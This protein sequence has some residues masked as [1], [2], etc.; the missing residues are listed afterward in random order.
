M[1][2]EEKSYYRYFTYIKPLTRLPLVKTYGTTI[3][4]IVVMIVFIIYAI[5][6]TIETILVL[7]KKVDDSNKV[8]QQVNQ[9]T[10]N[11]AKAKQNYENISPDIKSKIQSSIP[12]TVNLQS[13]IQNLEGVAKKYEA[14]ISALQ[15][16]PLVLQPK[17]EDIKEVKGSLSEVSFTFNIES[18]YQKLIAILQDLKSSDRLFF[19]DNVSLSNLTEGPGLIMSLSGKAYYIK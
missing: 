19:I 11:L 7:Q 8:L 13:V 16:Q 17:S 2:D 5:K 15:I 1:K 4:T 12:D 14:S 6:P 9:K 3:F 10:S 18:E